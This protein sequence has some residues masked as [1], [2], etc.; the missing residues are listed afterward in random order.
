MKAK[1]R[2]ERA[3]EK[4]ER[5]IHRLVPKIKAL[6]DLRAELKGDRAAKG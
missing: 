1:A 3:R 5:K 2:Y 4:Y 6:T